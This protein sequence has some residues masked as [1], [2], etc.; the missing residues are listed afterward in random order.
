M[1][2]KGGRAVIC[3]LAMILLLSIFAAGCSDSNSNM[4]KQTKE[5]ENFATKYEEIYKN[6][7]NDVNN[8]NAGYEDVK[9]QKKYL[10]DYHNNLKAAKVDLE[11]QNKYLQDLKQPDGF[12]NE[13]FG[14]MDA[15]VSNYIVAIDSF[16]KITETAN[17]SLIAIFETALS[18]GNEL[19]NSADKFIR[20]NIGKHVSSFSAEQSH[21]ISR[22]AKA[23]DDVRADIDKEPTISS[24]AMP[25]VDMSVKT[26]GNG[27]VI[28]SIKNNDSKT[29]NLVSVRTYAFDKAGNS[30]RYDNQT[31]FHSGL[32]SKHLAP[33]ASAEITWTIDKFAGS[34]DVI[35]Q[36]AYLRYDDAEAWTRTESNA[37]GKALTVRTK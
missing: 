2:M 37:E 29:I 33:D 6:M 28:L 4:K 23:Y 36:L 16:Q 9:N 14:F 18:K 35:L 8:I 12:N 32:S 3:M 11:K 17:P 26:D 13:Y 31:V 22:E 5:W 19:F 20:Q 25:K 15:A 30:I 34:D 10:V 7:Q 1:D 21:P 24:D 27:K